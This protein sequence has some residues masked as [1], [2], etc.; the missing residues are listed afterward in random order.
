MEN[1][2]PSGT[3]KIVIIV[4]LAIIAVAILLV[5][6]YLIGKNAGGNS[7]AKTTTTPVA[8][9]VLSKTKTTATQATA[10]N[11]TAGLK[12]YKSSQYSYQVK[13]PSSW[14]INDKETGGSLSFYTESNLAELRRLESEQAGTE[15]PFSE[16]VVVYYANLAEADGSNPPRY[17]SL[18]EMVHDISTYRDTTK[19]TFAGQEAYQTIEGG[20]VDFFEYVLEKDGHIYKIMIPDKTSKAELD[21]TEQNFLSSFKFT[22]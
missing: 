1:Q 12:T 11:T 7:I 4:I 22:N 21:S 9:A 17:S 15:G 14:V 19:T 20:M 10:T 18:D 3:G 5:I 13:Y 6:G 16:A 8:S 2:Q